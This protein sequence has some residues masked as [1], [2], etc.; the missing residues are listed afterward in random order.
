MDK[1]NNKINIK[2]LSD[3]VENTKE[4]Q[5]FR[6]KKKFFNRDINNIFVMLGNEC[7]LNCKY[8]LQHP[9]VHNRITHSINVDIYDFIEQCAKENSDESVNVQFFGGE[10]LLF[11]DNIKEIVN[12]MESRDCNVTFSL[13]TNGKLINTEIVDFVKEHNIWFAVSWD[14]DNSIKTRGF[15]AFESGTKTKI[16]L[17]NIPNLYLTA[18]LSSYAYPKD[19]L[20]SF[21]RINN[22]YRKIWGYDIGL[23]IDTIMDTGNL[24]KDLLDI[25][26]DLV[27]Q[28][29]R[30][31]TKQYIH[32]LKTDTLNDM[33]YTKYIWIN[34]LYNQLKNFYSPNGRYKGHYDSNICCCG[35]GYSTYNM[36]LEGNLYPCHNTSVKCGSIYDS[37]FTYLNRVMDTDNTKLHKAEC[38]K[39]PAIAY[40]HAGCK[41]VQDKEREE[42]Y[43]KLK[44]AVFVPLLNEILNM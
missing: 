27:S 7:N 6:I 14:G 22:E 31:M 24:P 38:A 36:D 9:L 34:T 12:T 10:P 2:E 4:S 5:Y 28:Q 39:C 21:N 25:D 3:K 44:R 42:S 37:Y 8:C 20:E 16:L 30:D 18:V 11:W 33:D 32:C 15:N 23:N 17:Y 41:F 26:Y 43:C 19:I 1:D 40:C 35:N 29:V 13:L